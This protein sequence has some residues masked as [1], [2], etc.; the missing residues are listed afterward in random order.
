[1]KFKDFIKFF[2][3]ELLVEDPYMI[4]V[5]EGVSLQKNPNLKFLWY[6]DMK[7]GLQSSIKDVSNFLGKE[8]KES[9]VNDLAE[10][11]DFDNM[12]KNPA[13]N[14]Q[15]RHDRFVCDNL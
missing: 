11:L 6:E 7:R 1:M 3:K 10:Y 4:H 14:H 12:K 5:Q 13:V 9:E 8:L 2:M 15:D